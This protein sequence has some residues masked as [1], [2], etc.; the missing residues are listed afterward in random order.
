MNQPLKLKN[1]YIKYERAISAIAL[2]SGFLFNA[3]FLKRVDLFWENFWVAIHILMCACAMILIN[4]EKKNRL[5]SNEKFRVIC[6]YVLQFTFGGLLSTFIVFYFRSAVL[7]VA[8]PFLLVLIIAFIV[9]ESYKH[10][11]SRMDF[12]ILFLFL[13]I[14][15]YFSFL[16]PIIFHAIGHSLFILAGLLSTALILLFIFFVSR[17]ASEKYKSESKTIFFSIVGILILFNS[18][19]I[20][21][22]IPPLPM[23]LQD[24]KVVHSI[25]KNSDGTYTVKSEGDEPFGFIK[26]LFGNYGTYHLTNGPVAYVY[27]SVFA[28]NNFAERIIHEWEYFDPDKKEWQTRFS[29]NLSVI[30][31]RDNGFRTY[32]SYT[33]LTPGSWRVEVRLPNGPVIGR[34]MFLA[35][36]E[37]F[38]DSRIKSEIIKN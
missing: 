32:S 28:P 19:Y 30:G 27:S 1:L 25:Y 35:S 29:T 20:L 16:I 8:W 4:Y 36:R 15:L 37:D 6:I 26:Q 12:Q 13:S 38:D 18:L 10:K 5:L 21:N 24:A 17:T 7:A 14:Y 22:V 2:V 11:Y 33:G 23:S 31:G 9:N 34:I 3:I